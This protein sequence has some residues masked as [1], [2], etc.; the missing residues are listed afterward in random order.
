MPN[1]CPDFGAG[2]L[3]FLWFRSLLPFPSFSGNGHAGNICKTETTPA[4][5]C[6]DTRP[7]PKNPFLAV[8]YNNN[9]ILFETSNDFTA[10][11]VHAISLCGKIADLLQYRRSR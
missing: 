9:F 8:L 1:S 6:F 5:M 11:T 10:R 4:S 2:L 3:L 7:I